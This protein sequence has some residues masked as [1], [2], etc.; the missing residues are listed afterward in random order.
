M[1][2]RVVLAG[3]AGVA[4]VVIFQGLSGPAGGYEVRALTAEEMRGA[5]VVDIRQPEEWAATGVIEGA[6][7]VTYADAQS[8]LAQVELQ[9]GQPLVL[10]CQ[11]GGR[12]GNAAAELAGMI[13]NPVISQDG[14]MSAWVNAG[15]PV[16]MP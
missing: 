4:A 8:F 15:H 10:V 14:G 9:P 7:L 2:R 13:A 5:M 12:S 3:L 11:S 1:D 16:V 6:K